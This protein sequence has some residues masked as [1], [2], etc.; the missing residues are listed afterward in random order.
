MDLGLTG[1]VALIT[2][3]GSPIGFGHA[4]AI[5]LAQEGCDIIANDINLDNAEKTAAE[6]RTLGR[7]ALAI[8]ADVGNIADV[9]AM[10]Q[11]ALA[12]LGKIDILVNNAGGPGAAGGPFVHTK[13][14]DWEGTINLILKG[15]LNCTKVVLPGM[16]ERKY[17][18][19]IN[20][21]SG[22]GRSGG[23]NSSVYSACKAAV[24]GFTKSVAQEVAPLGIN[25]NS[26]SPGL[27]TTNFLRGPD[28][29]I[30]N[31]ESLDKVRAT[32]PLG[33]L[34]EPRDVAPA[35]VY[36]ASDLAG[37][38]VGQVIPVEGGRFMSG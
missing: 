22:L 25:V 34:T 11:Q 5:L 16:I 33:R 15:V 17:G 38:I 4:T 29:K 10:V 26:V 9:R 23:P 6:A 1:K 32:I 7:Q 8:K 24:I 36:L 12:K 35:V 20:I 27:S 31:P 14:Q 21:S 18:K 13:E 28:G 3:A 19:I 2:G 37:D 30:R